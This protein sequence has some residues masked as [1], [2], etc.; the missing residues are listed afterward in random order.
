MIYSASLL[1]A[2]SQLTLVQSKIFNK[3]SKMHIGDAMKKKQILVQSNHQ[4]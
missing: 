2:I 4:W 3:T 1:Q